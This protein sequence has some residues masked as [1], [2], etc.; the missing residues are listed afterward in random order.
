MARM[1]TGY[2]YL[3]AKSIVDMKDDA[4]P[5]PKVRV[6]SS[7]SPILSF[8]HPLPARYCLSF[9]FCAPHQLFLPHPPK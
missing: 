5:D 3:E 8:S 7:S 9:F 1:E 2:I 6:S 4:L